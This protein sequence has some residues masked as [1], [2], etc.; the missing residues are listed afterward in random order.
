MNNE[1][2]A[3]Q[4]GQGEEDQQGLWVAVFKAEAQWSRDKDGEPGQ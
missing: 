3:K 4:A 1:Q 2:K